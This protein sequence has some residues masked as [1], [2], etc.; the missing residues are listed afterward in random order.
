MT[1][2]SSNITNIPSN[3]GTKEDPN[4]KHVTLVMPVELT[5]GHGDEEPLNEAERT[6][7]NFWYVINNVADLMHRM[8]T[9]FITYR[10][11]N[12]VLMPRHTSGKYGLWFLILT[13]GVPSLPSTAVLSE[14]GND[15][16]NAPQFLWSLVFWPHYPATGPRSPP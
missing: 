3:S 8:A 1:K 16:T 5:H 15:A 12:L 9:L 4:P 14:P 10:K 6:Q 7:F 2:D 13:W 11:R